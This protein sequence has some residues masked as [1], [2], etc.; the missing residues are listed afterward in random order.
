MGWKRSQNQFGCQQISWPANL[1]VGNDPKINL[2]ASKF[3][4]QPLRQELAANA[5]GSQDLV[6][7]IRSLRD[8]T[9][10]FDYGNL[11]HYGKK[12]LMEKTTAELN[13]CAQ[14]QLHMPV[15]A[16]LLPEYLRQKIKEFS[17]IAVATL[18]DQID[19]RN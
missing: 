9:R 1:W 8:P 12:F 4:G 10:D 3:R 11:K 19:I 16:Q 2:V 5:S 13:E 6:A 15:G 14:F 7:E 18:V 17:D